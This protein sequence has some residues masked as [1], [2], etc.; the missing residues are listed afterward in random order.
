MQLLEKA[1]ATVQVTPPLPLP[2][3]PEFEQTQILPETKLLSETQV[4]LTDPTPRIP[5]G[6][7]QPPFAPTPPRVEP[8][9]KP[10]AQTD[11]ASAGDGVQ[12]EPLT[13]SGILDRTF[14]ICKTH[15]WKLLAIVGIPW[16]ITAVISIVL[17][18]LIAFAGLTVK[19]LGDLAPWI[20]IVA[21]VSV[22]PS[23]AVFLVGLFYLSQGAVIYA[24]SSIYLGREVLVKEAY[25]FVLNRLG[26]FFLTSCLFMLAALVLVCLP[27]VLGVLLYFLFKM[28]TSS[29]WWSAVTWL[30]LAVI[31]FYGLT[32]LLLFDKVVIIEDEAYFSALTRSWSLLTGKAD[33]P[34]P[35]GYF[36]RFVILLNLF[37]LINM[38]ISIVFSTPGTLFSFLLPSPQWLGTIVNQVLTSIG[39]LIT[40]VF[41][42]VCMVVFYYDIRN[43]KEGFDLKVLAGLE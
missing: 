43:R 39:S 32:K 2:T 33:S 23:L 24:V 13:L 16:A 34:W 8:P 21:G 10:V 7:K 17:V 38:A 31:P 41:G 5:Q 28:A 9:L 18:I 26:R 42:S 37:L 4:S 3:V 35:R 30:P 12:I 40:G 6:L 14:Q 27:V 1:G 15:F 20:L 11:D 25:R 29:G 19:N 22:L 36:L